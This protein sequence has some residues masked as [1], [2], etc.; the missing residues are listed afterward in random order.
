MTGPGPGAAVQRVREA[1]EAHGSRVFGSGNHL[2][3][4]CPVH[5]SHGSPTL[6]VRQGR[7]WALIYCHAACDTADVL[8]A[9]G[10][11]WD[12]IANQPRNGHATQRPVR[13]A[14]AID[15]MRNTVMRAVRLINME[16]AMGPIPEPEIHAVG[17][18]E[19]E[20]ADEEREHFHRVTARHAALATDDDYVKQALATRWNRRSY[21]QSAVLTVYREDRRRG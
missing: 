7:D 11:S 14:T 3:A 6:D 2:R 9:L 4:V 15:R 8:A 16:L 1:L 13:P 19:A 18:A 21:E 12:D 20:E 5:E 17:F 10:L